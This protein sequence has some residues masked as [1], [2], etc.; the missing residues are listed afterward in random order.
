MGGDFKN[1]KDMNLGND[2]IL[3]CYIGSDAISEAYLGEDLVFSSGPFVGMKMSPK[4]MK[5]MDKAINTGDTF[6]L[7]VKSS[8]D[9]TLTTDADWFTLSPTTG[10]GTGNKEVVTLTVVSIPSAETA[11]TITC[12]SANYSASTSTLFG[13]GYGIPANEIWYATSN[14]SRITSL[15][16]WKV[17]DKNGN[18]MANSNV[19][20]STYGK[21]VFPNDIGYVAG[22]P[23]QTNNGWLYLT[24]LGLPEMEPSM[25][26]GANDF[27]FRYIAQ[28]L[29]AWTRVY[30]DYEY[31]ND[32]ET[33][34]WGSDGCGCIIA[35]GKSGTL[36]I[37]EG[38]KALGAYCLN[39]SKWEH[40]IFPTSFTGYTGYQDE[41]AGGQHLC[42]DMASLQTVKYQTLAAPRMY[43]NCWTRINQS[44]IVYYPDGGT[45]YGTYHR[46]NNFTFQT[47]TP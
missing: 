20:F 19:D 25:C 2:E 22:D 24:E 4:T 37:P 39:R 11:N 9:W 30:G 12:T 5:F 42:E 31:I 29:T 8:E 21:M 18:Q 45:G 1:A 13:I 35:R 41:M 38:V 16:Q 15:N 36:T 23:Y 47:Y 14:E 26:I 43:G 3:E 7:S 44:G 6:N 28:P 34:A 40:I 10:L 33:M 27:G 46:P 32:E 17:Y